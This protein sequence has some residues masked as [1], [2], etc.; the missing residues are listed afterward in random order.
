MIK[1]MVVGFVL[2]GVDATL[3][4]VWDLRTLVQFQGS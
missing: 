1:R 2:L 4:D 3:S